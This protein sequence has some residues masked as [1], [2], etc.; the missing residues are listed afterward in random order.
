MATAKPG[1]TLLALD[2]LHVG[3]AQLMLVVEGDE[4]V[5][6]V[7]QCDV[8]LV[9][10]DDMA[11]GE[12]DS[13]IR[14]ERAGRARPAC[15]GQPD[16]VDP[17]ARAAIG[18]IHAAIGVEQEQIRTIF[19]CHD[20]VAFHAEENV[21][22]RATEVRVIAVAA[23]K[24]VVAGFAIQLV[25]AGFAVE[26]IIVGA[27]VEKVVS[28]VAIDQIIATVATNRVGAVG[29]GSPFVPKMSFPAPR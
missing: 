26:P 13:P 14:A 21:V 29:G 12:L 20:V 27:A 7:A 25:V 10:G 22:A 4:P 19:T 9:L 15:S 8:V 24:L 18:R 6:V 28:A 5:G 3:K 17:A 16:R 1:C 2:P 23:I 11:A